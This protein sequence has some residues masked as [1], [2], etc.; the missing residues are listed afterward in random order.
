MVN[1]DRESVQRILTEELNMKKLC[2]KVVPKMLLAEQ[3]K[4]QKE[5]C[6]DLL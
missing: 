6:S 5:I 2:A 1:L 4:L 3:K